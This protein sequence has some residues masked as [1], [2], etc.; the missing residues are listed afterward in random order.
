MPTLVRSGIASGL[1]VRGTPWFQAGL[2]VNHLLGRGGVL[3]PTTRIGETITK[4]ATATYHF[5]I[6]PRYQATRRMWVVGISSASGG[7]S[8]IT[9]TDPSSTVQ[10]ITHAG[11]TQRLVTFI[12]TISSRT[13]AETAIAITIAASNS[14]D[15]VAPTIESIACFE[16]PRT[17]L[18][19]DTNDNGVDLSTLAGGL[20]IYDDTGKSL[21]G[22]VDGTIAALAVTRRCGLYHVAR[23][24]LSPFS[25]TTTS[26]VNPLSSTMP[27]LDRKKY[28]GETARD[29]EVRAYGSTGATTTM[30][31][32]VT[33]TGVG[34]G[35]S[36][37]SWTAGD[38]G[39]W[40]STTIE[41]DV[42][43]LTDTRG[44]QGGAV[45]LVTIEGKRTT[46]ANAAHLHSVCIGGT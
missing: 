15:Y 4:G 22:V 6:W 21:G 2:A 10:G 46:G 37:L 26:Y 41:V 42:D 12:E 36:V 9:F 5:T 13:A 34:G 18:V 44:L 35:S 16:L 28:R 25:F 27:V 30:D 20:W 39:S 17:E 32:R 1:P 14:A 23:S 40:K 11:A 3:I 38:A 7:T 45:C 31:V 29:V 19:A 43:D 8:A 33:S 24:D